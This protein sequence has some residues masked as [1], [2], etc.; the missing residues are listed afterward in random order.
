MVG[1]LGVGAWGVGCGHWGF[2]G[3][4]GI[5]HLLWDYQETYGESPRGRR[6]ERLKLRISTCQHEDLQED[7][8]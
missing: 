5:K 1:W 7:T 3:P 8:P 4:P 2:G 6:E